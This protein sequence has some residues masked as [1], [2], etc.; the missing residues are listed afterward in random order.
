MDVE[1]P[2]EITVHLLRK[3]KFCTLIKLNQVPSG[4]LTWYRNSGTLYS[5]VLGPDSV[6]SYMPC[7]LT[8]LGGKTLLLHRDN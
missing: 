7:S 3:H 5:H 4:N 2:S 1:T 8:A 6:C